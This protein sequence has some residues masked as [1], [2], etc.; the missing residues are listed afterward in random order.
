ML[1]LILFILCFLSANCREFK[2]IKKLK[3]FSCKMF[4]LKLYLCWSKVWRN[5]WNLELWNYDIMKLWNYEIM[6]LWYYEIM[7][8]WYYETIKLWKNKIMK[9]FDEK[10]LIDKL[11]VNLEYW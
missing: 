5:W 7:K 6:K 8:L 4:S 3:N 10:M 2:V 11:Y 1:K 9:V